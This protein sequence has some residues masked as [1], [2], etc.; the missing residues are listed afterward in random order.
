MNKVNEKNKKEFQRN[1]ETINIK[2][3]MLLKSGEQDKLIEETLN[4]VYEE[5]VEVTK[6]HIDKVLNVAFDNKDNETF[7]PHS[8]C[9]QKDGNKL[10]FSF[11]KSNKALL[12]LFLLGF[13]FIAGFATFS[14]VQLI[15]KSWM[16]IDLNGDGVPDINIDEDGDGKCDKNCTYVI[17]KKGGQITTGNGD[18]TLDTAALIVNFESGNNIVLTDIYPDD[19]TD[20]GVTTKI[21]DVKFTIENKT[22]EDL[23]YNIYWTEVENTF[24]TDNF[25][26]MI[27]STN[28]GY[29][30]NWKTAPK[31]NGLEASRIKISPQSKQEYTASFT[32]HG[33]GEEQNIDQGKVFKGRL[34]IELIKDNK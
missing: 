3:F 29:K 34:L 28:N 9:V 7:L 18:V 6:K 1:K 13:L 10:I 30:V 2:E 17:D 5:N 14:G 4:K 27:T 12:I 24:E 20:E 23:Y 25:W 19:Q 33:T 11:K 26:T 8:L 16:N 21:P 22:N 15:G 31:Q 32:L